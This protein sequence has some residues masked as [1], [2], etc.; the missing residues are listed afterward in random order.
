MDQG[1]EDRL[2]EIEKRLAALEAGR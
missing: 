1:V 2:I